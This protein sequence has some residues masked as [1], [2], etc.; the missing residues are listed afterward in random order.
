MKQRVGP[1]QI[2]QVE[3]AAAVGV[4]SAHTIATDCS[5]EAGGAVLARRGFT[6]APRRVRKRKRK[7]G[8]MSV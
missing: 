8:T 4:A 2:D 6:P 7:V 1:R 3:R 5:F